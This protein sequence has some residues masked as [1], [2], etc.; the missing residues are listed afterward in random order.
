MRRCVVGALSILLLL[1][2]RVLSHPL[3]M[4]ERLGETSEDFR[5]SAAVA[6][7]G[8]LLRGSEHRGAAS[9]DGVLSLARGALGRDP[10]GDRAEFVSLVEAFRR[11]AAAELESEEEL[12]ER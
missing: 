7:F 5:F 6:S 10:H 11:I 3:R 1:A 2:A 4:P 8:M 12:A 9:V